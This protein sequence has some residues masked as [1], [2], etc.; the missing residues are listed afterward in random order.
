MNNLPFSSLWRLAQLTG[1]A[2]ILTC[3]CTVEHMEVGVD[4][5]GVGGQD[6]EPNPS[7]G[8]ECSEDCPVPLVC[9]ICNDDAQSCATPKVLCNADGSCGEIKWECP[10]EPSSTPTEPV[11]PDICAAVCSGKPEPEL[12]NGCPIPACACDEPPPSSSGDCE[13]AVPEICKLCDDN[14]CA[15]PNV[16]CNADGSC[17]E[18]TYT[19]PSSPGECP[20]P[21]TLCEAQC[22]GKVLDVAPDCP[23]SDCDCEEP[24]ACDCPIPEIC[25]QCED[26]SCAKGTRTCDA[27]GECSAVLWTC[28]TPAEPP[29]DCNCAIDASCQ[30]C[31]DGS[32]A[33]GEVECLPDGSCGETTWTCP[34]PAPTHD[35]DITNV[36]CDVAIN[37]EEGT[38][39][40]RNGD[41]Y[42]PCVAPEQCGEVKPYDCDTSQ[43]TCKVAVKC[44]DGL[45]ATQEGSC[46]G[47][48]VA[49]EECAPAKTECPDE[50]PVPA[51]CLECDDGECASPNV[52]CNEDGTC[53]DLTWKCSNGEEPSSAE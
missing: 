51:V 36:M 49:P 29:P 46:Y 19:C 23:V 43:V 33:K 1:F 39:P 20:D 4:Q 14:T 41:C 9:Q 30:V 35:C 38:V 48:C 18:V 6:N 28:P 32:C 42:G 8:N 37:C 5:G 52:A 34:S 22:N 10:D 26:G 47:P 40:T 15:T 2:A 17:G 44:E 11:C 24:S 53:G 3:A 31:D 25:Q 16:E 50:C 27:D 13:C 12:P 7:D 21:A 45:V